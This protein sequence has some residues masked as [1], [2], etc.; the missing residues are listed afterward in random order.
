MAIDP[1]VR[2]T[3]P[4][5]DQVRADGGR[6]ISEGAT[7]GAGPDITETVLAADVL[8]ISSEALASSRAEG[9]PTGTV[10]AEQLRDI[11]QRLAD[12]AYDTPD[13]T[14]RV[15]EQVVREINLPVAWGGI[16]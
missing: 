15:S 13:V 14:Q 6:R 10:T 16:G 5:A 9:I 2:P 12:G 7:G 4:R 3:P 1:V 8:A 11:R